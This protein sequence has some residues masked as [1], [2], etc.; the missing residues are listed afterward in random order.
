MLRKIVFIQVLMISFIFSFD[1]MQYVKACES[2]DVSACYTLA[3]HLTTGKN[4]ENQDSMEEGKGY[5][6]RACVYGEKRACDYLGVNYLKE[7]SY[8]AA[9]PYL[10][11]SC[12]RGIKVACE[13]VGTIYR[14][15]HDVKQSD[16]KAREFYDRA[17]TL[18]S[19]DA[20][21]NVAIMYRGGFGVEK[22]KVLEKKYYNK[23][24]KL[25]LKVSCEQ[26]KILDNV[27]KGI[28]TGF[29][30]KIKNWFQ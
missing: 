20:C 13:S 6:R 1:K 23:G 29:L 19:A 14:D 8:G 28:E 9:R 27:E 21:H 5:M 10:V 15:G 17:C 24:C 18:K 30:E 16:V 3:K 26:Y 4:A 7:K 12:S 2:N 11:D 22:S 25:G